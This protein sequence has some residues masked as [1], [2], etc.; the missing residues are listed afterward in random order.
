MSDNKKTIVVSDIHMCNGEQKLTKAAAEKLIKMLDECVISDNN[1][2]K[3]IMLGDIFDTWVCKTYETPSGIKPIIDFWNSYSNSFISKLKEV[4]EKKEVH[5][6]LGNHDATVIK[7]EELK[8]LEENGL[9]NLKIPLPGKNYYH[10]DGIWMEHGHAEDMMCVM[11]DEEG[12]GI[13]GY[14]LG[15]FLSRIWSNAKDPIAARKAFYKIFKPL[16]WLGGSDSGTRYD[17]KQM[18]KPGSLFDRLKSI[19]EWIR[20]KFV[21][22]ILDLL[23]GILINLITSIIML[24]IA[25][26]FALF[27]CGVSPFSKIK[28][29]STD[30]DVYVM[31]LF[32]L[33]ISMLWCYA[34]K[35][36]FDWWKCINSMLASEGDLRWFA[37]ERFAK[38]GIELVVFGHTHQ[39]IKP[40]EADNYAN[41]GCVCEGKIQYVEINGTTAEVKEY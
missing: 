4:A 41:D 13:Q 2:T 21:W 34:W 10:E 26:P 12:C 20:R 15:Y 33:S 22:F 29:Q 7:K 16:K 24:L 28:M 31:L 38:D 6:I 39:I 17:G 27:N 35:W 3:L 40:I 25:L 11:T 5:Y 23:P 30:K 32:P 19:S 14:P 8:V 9:K 36:R 1:V 18:P 37:S